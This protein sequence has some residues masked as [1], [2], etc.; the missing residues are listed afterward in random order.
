MDNNLKIAGGSYCYDLY[1]YLTD[2]KKRYA[3]ENILNCELRPKFLYDD[4]EQLKIISSSKILSK[5]DR[6]EL[7][8][9]YDKLFLP[10]TKNDSISSFYIWLVKNNKCY[11]IDELVNKLD[12][13]FG[14][15]NPFKNDMYLLDPNT[16]LYNRKYIKFYPTYSNMNYDVK[17]EIVKQYNYDFRGNRV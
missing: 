6:D 15:S 16:F 11:I 1:N 14:S 2:G 10:E 17:R 8:Q 3:K 9:F 12:K 13:L 4:L 7:Y 5:T